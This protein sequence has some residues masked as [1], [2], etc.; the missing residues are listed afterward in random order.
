M[1]SFAVSMLCIKIKH[2][3]TCQKKEAEVVLYS[4]YIDLGFYIWDFLLDHITALRYLQGQTGPEVVHCDVLAYLCSVLVVIILFMSCG[5][6][7]PLAL[8]STCSH[9]QTA[10][11][12]ICPFLLCVLSRAEHLLW[13]RNM[14]SKMFP[15]RFLLTNQRYTFDWN[16]LNCISNT[17]VIK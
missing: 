4:P 13:R 9:W 2:T 3:L 1:E 8:V 17:S 11:N 10:S 14:T 15:S 5:T 7:L 6:N 16:R 12:V